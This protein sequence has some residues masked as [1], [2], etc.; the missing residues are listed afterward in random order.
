MYHVGILFYFRLNKQEIYYKGGTTMA[1][2]SEEG[3]NKL[4]EELR[5]LE[6]VQRPAIS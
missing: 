1:Y 3:Y 2:M 4:L 5:E 6:S